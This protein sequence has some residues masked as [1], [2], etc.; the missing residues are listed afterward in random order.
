[1]PGVT[2]AGK[3]SSPRTPQRG[4][5]RRAATP[6]RPPASRQERRLEQ[7][8]AADV[9][10]ARARAARRTPISRVRSTTATSMMF[11]ITM[12]PTPSETEAISSDRM[13]AAAEICRHS[14]LQALGGDDAERIGGAEGGV[15]QRAHHRAHLVDRG[16]RR[17]PRRRG[18]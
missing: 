14:V 1:M 17:R 4:Q 3:S 18:P 5:P 11:M 10:L 15:A 6:T 16:A 12:P 8:L 2:W 13:K 9:A 7:E